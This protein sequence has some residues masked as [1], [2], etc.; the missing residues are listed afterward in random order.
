VGEPAPRRH[1][2][3]DERAEKHRASVRAYLDDI[4]AR[5]GVWRFEVGEND[6]VGGA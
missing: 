5:V 1:C 6:L 2:R 4:F 3:V